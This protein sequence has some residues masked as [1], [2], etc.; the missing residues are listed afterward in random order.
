MSI[1]KPEET[2]PQV[3]EVTKASVR[4]DFLKKS[5][6]GIVVTSL[7]AQSVWGACNASGISGGSGSTT[8]CELPPLTN[9]RSPGS[10]G[11]F[12]ESPPL[13]NV[14][15]NKVK[16]MFATYSSSNDATL[17]AKFCDL[18]N[19]IKSTTIVLST[20]GGAI[21]YATLHLGDALANNGGIWNLAAYYLNA[22]FGFYT[23]PPEFA[24]ADELIQHVWAALYVANDNNTP[25][26]FDSLTTSFTDGVSSQ[27]IP[28]YGA[29]I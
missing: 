29:C 10:W 18:N 28:S 3:S 24:D 17:N 12:I 20:G 25:T 15:R 7:P 6:I 13:G 26:N 5:A 8:T 23:I 9:G 21:P 4:R 14:H 2:N 11:K 27:A 19:H 16:A 1:D 22:E